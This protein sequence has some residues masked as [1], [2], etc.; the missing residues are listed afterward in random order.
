MLARK[1]IVI[2]LK[3]W[4]YAL[5]SQNKGKNQALVVGGLFSFVSLNP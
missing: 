4:G 3:F 5:A 2:K 1:N